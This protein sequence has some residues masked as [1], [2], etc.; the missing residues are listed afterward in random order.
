MS[1]MQLNKPFLF[2]VAKYF[3]VEVSEDASKK[4]ICAA[5]AAAD[6]PVT[7][8][9]YKE[10]FPDI[11]ATKDD[12]D[13]VNEKTGAAKQFTTSDEPVVI[14]MERGNPRYEVRGYK[15]T[16]E[17]P[18]LVV[19]RPDAD[20]IVNNVFGFRIATTEEVKKYYS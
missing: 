1:F 9:L 19:S 4:D 15:F 16:K 11:E 18:F 20:F 13:D 14:K 3:G 8:E 2:D 17:H 6:P 5:F 7:W 12:D 10:S